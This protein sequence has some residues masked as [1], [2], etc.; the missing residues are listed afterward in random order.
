MTAT[1]VDPWESSTLADCRKLATEMIGRQTQFD[2]AFFICD[3]HDVEYKCRLWRQS[4]P[5]IVPYY[6]VKSNPDPLLCRVL[7]TNGVKF[8]CSNQREIKFVLENVPGAKGSDMVISNTAKCV[9]DI[10]FSFEIGATLMT[11]D[12]VE[13][14]VK[15][16][17]FRER[18]RILIRLQSS[19]RTSEITFN[20]KFGADNDTILKILIKCKELDLN[21]VGTHFHVGLGFVSPLIYDESIELS[22]AVFDIAKEMGFTMNILNIGGSFPGGVRRRK[23]FSEV[24]AVVQRSLERNFPTGCGVTVIAEPGQFFSTS[25]WILCTK[26]VAVK[27]TSIDKTHNPGAASDLRAR[28]SRMQRRHLKL[29]KL[30]ESHS[31]EEVADAAVG[32]IVA[33]EH[34]VVLARN[35]FLNESRSNVIPRAALPYLDLHFY[36]VGKDEEIPDIGDGGTD[37]KTVLWGATCNPIDHILEWGHLVDFKCNEWILID[38][39]GTYSRAFQC[40]FNGFGIPPVHYIGHGARKEA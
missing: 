18:A 2:E 40:G 15:I 20:R 3:L 13:E 36:R 23:Q 35:V 26:V 22:R 27:D 29:N 9:K 4:M 24:A 8:D 31:Q 28:L 32:G 11:V 10:A 1:D 16:V 38:N 6:A 34:H 30:G 12:S 14:L 21:V 19:E 25:A 37:S 39:M 33:K 17:P 5:G 7:F